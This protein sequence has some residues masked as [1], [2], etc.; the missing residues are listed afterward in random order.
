MKE[1]Q[2]WCYLQVKLCDLC[3]SALSVP[4]WPK[5]HYINTLPFLFPFLSVISIQQLKHNIAKAG[6]LGLR[7]KGWFP[8]WLPSCSSTWT[9]SSVLTD[10]L[11]L[12]LLLS[13]I[14][15]LTDISHHI[16]Q[17][18]LYMVLGLHS[19]IEPGELLQWLRATL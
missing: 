3:R 16:I 12:I 14:M 18:V 17:F 11:F 19:S 9:S 8:S 4:P 15:V 6:W 7:I 1:S 10:F 13:P 5:R 2:A